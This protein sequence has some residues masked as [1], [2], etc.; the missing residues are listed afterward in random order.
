MYMY[1]VV[2]IRFNSQRGRVCVG[3]G[4]LALAVVFNSFL[5]IIGKVSPII[6]SEAQSDSD[7]YARQLPVHHTQSTRDPSMVLLSFRMSDTSNIGSCL[8]VRPRK[9]QI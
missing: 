4:Y 6:V 9:L 5:I 8:F 3:L 7:I 1:S 2:G